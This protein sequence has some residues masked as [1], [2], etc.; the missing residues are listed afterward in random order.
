LPDEAVISTPDGRHCATG[1]PRRSS[2]SKSKNCQK[3]FMALSARN[4]AVVAPM[5]KNKLASVDVA[6]SAPISVGAVA[7]DDKL[8]R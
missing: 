5:L 8:R 6:I 3:F 4:A 7:L 2:P 1:G